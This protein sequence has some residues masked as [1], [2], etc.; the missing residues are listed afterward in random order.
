MSPLRAL[1][2]L[3]LYLP[4]LLLFVVLS[5]LVGGPEDDCPDWAQ[6]PLPHRTEASEG[7]AFSLSVRPAREEVT[8]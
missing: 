4:H 2:L 6:M 5:V 8:A 1:A 7:E 3:P